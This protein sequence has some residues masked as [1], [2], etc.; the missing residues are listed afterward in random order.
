[1]D[2]PATLI[3]IPESVHRYL[4]SSRLQSAVDLLLSGKSPKTPDGLQWDE[5]QDFYRACLAAQQTR[6]EWAITLEL[7]WTAVFA[8]Q[9]SGWRPSGIK[10]QYDDSDL[11]ID[12]QHLW[13]ESEFARDLSRD[14]YYMEALVELDVDDGVRIAVCLYKDGSPVDLP[15]VAG[16]TRIDEWIYS[17][18]EPITDNP[19]LD[20]TRLRGA[21]RAALNAVESAARAVR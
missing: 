19:R 16:S 13:D 11:R 5:L 15:P 17:A 7:F 2:D 18:W 3:S 14:G 21:A 6:I 4:T 12:V 8:D 10:E 1:M 9:V 20:C